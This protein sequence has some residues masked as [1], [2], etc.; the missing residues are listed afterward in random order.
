MESFFDPKGKREQLD[1]LHLRPERPERTHRV[2]AAPSAS[3][4]TVKWPPPTSDG[5]S[6][7]TGY[8]VT[9]SSPGLASTRELAGPTASKA[10][11]TD[12]QAGAPCTFSVRAISKL[13]V[14]LSGLSTPVLPALGDNGYLVETTDGAVLGF[15][16]VHAHGGVAGEG[17]DV[18]GFATT[19]SGLGYWVVTSTGAVTPFGNAAYFGQAA[20]TTSRPSPPCPMARATG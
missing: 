17:T 3:G 9:A 1:Q 15:G 2:V 8:I 4:V 16:D 19:P 20:A 14:G 11:F 18:V 10:V 12:L 5:G 7:V 6:P 13:G